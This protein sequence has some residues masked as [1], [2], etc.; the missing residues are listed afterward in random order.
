MSIGQFPESLSQ[1]ILVGINLGREIERMRSFP[2]SPVLGLLAAARSMWRGAPCTPTSPRPVFVP[3][4]AT[5][6]RVRSI[7]ILGI[8]KLRISESKFIVNDLWILQFHPWI[9][10]VWLSQH[11]DSIDIASILR[12]PTP[13]WI[14]ETPQCEGRENPRI[15]IRGILAWR[16]SVQ[17]RLQWR[18]AARRLDQAAPSK[19]Q[20]PAS[21]KGKLAWLPLRQ[22]VREQRF[23]RSK[24]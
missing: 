20:G 8:H 2:I 18:L 11:S 23:P 6:G 5:L 17:E 21:V 7:R 22:V 12:A 14:C 9:L 10:R 16:P 3:R 19:R 24:R 1:A 15:G 13:C 4:E